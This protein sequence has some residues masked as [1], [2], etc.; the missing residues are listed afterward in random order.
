MNN[1]K[2]I[3]KK[4]LKFYLKAYKIDS[5][6]LSNQDLNN[7]ALIYIDYKKNPN[8][9]MKYFS[10]VL[11]NNPKDTTALS[12]L[13]FSYF[14]LDKYKEAILCFEKAIEYNKLYANSYFGIGMAYSLLSEHEEAIDYYLKGIEIDPKAEKIYM[15]NA[16]SMDSVLNLI[17]TK[18]SYIDSTEI[19]SYKICLD[20]IASWNLTEND[21][22]FITQDAIDTFNSIINQDN[23]ASSYANCFLRLINQ[24]YEPFSCS[25]ECNPISNFNNFTTNIIEKNEDISI[26]ISPNPTE[27]SFKLSM[28]GSTNK[29]K[30]IFIYDIYGK[31]LSF[32]EMKDNKLNIDLSSYCT[33]IYFVN[34]VLDN[35][36][37]IIKKVIKK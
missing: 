34:C 26:N 9:V 6:S 19:N 28:N 7:I 1:N 33:G 37:T 24:Q 11:N 25:I 17:P 32:Q 5:N 21:S 22:V 35:N 18:Y 27:N 23:F 10:K 20:S 8:E 15:N 30:D 4:A 36:K 16:I 12:D 3:Y 14:F 29:I 31:L 2:T 13:G